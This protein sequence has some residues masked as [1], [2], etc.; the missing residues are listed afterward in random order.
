MAG[1]YER[2][3]ELAR[4]ER[5][6]LEAGDWERVT[7]LQAEQAELREA[8]SGATPPPSAR[9]A[10]EEAARLNAEVVLAIRRAMAGVQA[11]L[12]ALGRGREAAAGYGGAGAERVPQVAWQG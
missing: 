10:L 11:E 8:L 1:P 6:A 12:V 2:L 3:L 4:R 7:A 9:P 5:D